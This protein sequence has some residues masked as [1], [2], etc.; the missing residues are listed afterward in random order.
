MLTDADFFDKVVNIL[1]DRFFFDVE[2]WKFALLHG[3]P[4]ALNEYLQHLN[5][6]ASSVST[7]LY[8]IGS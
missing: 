1:R 2:I 6:Q 7:R 3:N 8:T 5:N 4:Q